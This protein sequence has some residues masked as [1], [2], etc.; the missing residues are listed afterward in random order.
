M[1]RA[2]ASRP[3]AVNRRGH[4]RDATVSGIPA[5]KD[6]PFTTRLVTETTAAADIAFRTGGC[7]TLLASIAPVV[8]G[9]TVPA[10]ERDNLPFYA[11]LAELGDVDQSFPRPTERVLVRSRPANPFAR[12][13]ASGGTVENI[14]FESP[15]QTVNPALNEWWS[16][17][18]TN[19]FA[20][21]QHWRHL[22][23]PRPTLCV[24]H[25]FMGSAYLLNAAFFSLSW[26]FQQG[27]DVLL[28][29]LPFHG[30]RAAQFSPFSGH[31]FFSHGICGL[32]EAMAQSIHDFRLFADYLESTGVQQ[33]G[34]TGISLGGY[35]TALLAATDDRWQ[36]AIPN[37]PVASIG[38]L[39]PGWLPIQPVLDQGL[40]WGSI[41]KEL[42]VRALR[43]SSPLTYPARVPHDRR[44][45]VVGLGDR[46]APPAQSEMLWQHWD[47]SQLHW[48]PGNHI[49]HLGQPQYLRA[50]ARFMSGNG[51]APVEWTRA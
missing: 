39:L 6:L 31:G 22:D 15:Y 48:F 23:G 51:F 50:M 41:D 37:V 30:Q 45:I 12:A 5:I 46:L 26:F 25:G 43:Y 38:D 11:E 14:S 36:V 7:I 34:V 20:H 2:P 24:V 3:T 28:Y 16:G 9:H 27:Y 17:F 44:F 35:T 21:A 13:M 47:H 8:I 49:L 19:T 33:I 1:T 18:Q 29:T 32:N 40:R 4:G 42:T 10:R